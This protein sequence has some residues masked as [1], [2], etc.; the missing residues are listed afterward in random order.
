MP[1]GKLSLIQAMAWAA[2][3][4]LALFLGTGTVRAQSNSAS[5]T[6]LVAAGFLCDPG[7]SS[8]C[9]AVVKSA[10]GDSY[11]I[12]GAG[13]LTTQ[14]KSVTAAGT[15]THK[16]SNGLVIEAGVWI[17][18]ELASFDSYGIA[19]GALMRDG[20]ALGPR[21]MDLSRGLGMFSGS[22]AAGGLAVLRIPPLAGAGDIEKRDAAS[23]LCPRQSSFRTPGG[24][25]KSGFGGRKCGIRRGSQRACPFPFGQT[26]SYCDGQSA[27]SEARSR[28][29]AD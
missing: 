1:R 26:R 24:R 13:T 15:F 3:P 4:T 9:P 14:S 11:E 5:Y 28:T 7:D 19:P 23:E 6:F 21:Q 27:R 22:M 20:R 17:A 2:A 18:S 25:D 29:P 8:A 10:N 12:T 16:S